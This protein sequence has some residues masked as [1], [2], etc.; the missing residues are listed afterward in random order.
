MLKLKVMKKYVVGFL[1]G[2]L[3]VFSGCVDEDAYSLSKM[4]VG[5]GI[6]QEINVEAAEYIIIMDNGD[7]LNPVISDYYH[8]W[9]YYSDNDSHS[10]FKNGDRIL[11]NYTVLGDDKNDAGEIVE[12]FVKVNS[13]KKILM[14]GIL[15]IT[16]E[17]QDSIGNDPVIVQDYWM[18]DSLLNFKISY[19]GNNKV[20]FINLVKQ[21]GELTLAN[22]PIE[23]EL[24]HNENGDEQNIPFAAYVSF[25]LNE[26]EIAG[27]DSVQFVVNSTDYDGNSYSYEGTYFYGQ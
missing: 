18:T 20:H 27:I 21:P 13:I 22:Q 1:I 7:V 17:N 9:Y 12:F 25:K 14:K 15:D 5:F 6:I 19:W 3:F 11:I 26:L 4:W 23:L 16:S 10:V 8:P 2:F 24:R